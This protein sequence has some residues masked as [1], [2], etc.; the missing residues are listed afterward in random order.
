MDQQSGLK[1]E[2][3]KLQ[4]GFKLAIHTLST[5]A[6][7]TVALIISAIAALAGVVSKAHATSD[8][9]TVT[10]VA[11]FAGHRSTLHVA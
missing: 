8:L 4:M 5:V 2:L 9:I 10:I 1:F 11:A 3:I 7:V 6:A